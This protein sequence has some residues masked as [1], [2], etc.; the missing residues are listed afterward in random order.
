M[1][2]VPALLS[3]IGTAMAL[4]AAVLFT[5]AAPAAAK[6]PEK[7]ITIIVGYGAGG[8]TDVSS[9]ILAEKL[10]KI[11]GVNVIVENKPGAGGTLAW[12]ATLD[13]EADGYT[14]T[15]FA[16]H[17]YV[18]SVMLDR[19]ISL[20]DFTAI[21]SIMPQQRVLFATNSMPFDTMEGMI[22]Y[23]KKTPVTFADGGL[24]WASRVVEAFAKKN[25]LKIR[26]VPFKSG[27]EGSAA[28]LGGHVSI[29][30]TGVGTGAWLGAT[31][32]GTLKILGIL[33]PGDLE[34]VGQKG[35]RSIGT[36]GADYLTKVYYGYAVKAGTPA[37]RVAIIS[38][39]IEKALKDPDVAAKFKERDL[40]PEWI[41][42]GSYKETLLSLT[43]EAQKLKAYLA[44]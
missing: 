2:M 17:D 15:S 32:K 27:A 38:D 31:R 40:I 11:L 44:E 7:P 42:P 19:K 24:Y 35:V 3:R 33:S 9:R 23:T 4:A 6:F 14:I 29:G 8:M 39:A 43:D 13:R 34:R 26:L 41:P 21:G 1:T 36:V 16:T 10:E 28:L 12:T 25:D 30:E 5:A 37:D 20:D 22:E 18:A